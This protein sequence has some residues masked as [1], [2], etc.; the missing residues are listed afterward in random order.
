MAIRPCIVGCC[1]AVL[2][3]IND[4]YPVVL[5][6]KS[7][8]LMMSLHDNETVRIRISVISIMI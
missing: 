6:R 5:V 2:T 8:C 3:L 1:L 4:N 7:V